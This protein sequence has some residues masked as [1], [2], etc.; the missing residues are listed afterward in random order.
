MSLDIKVCCNL[1]H[2]THVAVWERD[3]GETL[4]MIPLGED[5]D[6]PGAQDKARRIIEALTATCFLSKHI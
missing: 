2:D 1:K 5:F 6:I 4:C 3:S